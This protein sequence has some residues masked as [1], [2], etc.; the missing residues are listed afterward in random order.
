[1]TRVIYV[2]L[3]LCINLFINYFI[4]LSVV[5]ILNLTLKRFRLV[6][7][8]SL[9]A[10]Y[11]FAI[12]L[13]Q[14]NFFFSL[15]IK[16]IMSVSIVLL[17]FGHTKIRLF[18]KITAC[19]YTINFLFAGIIFFIWYFISANGIFMKNGMMYFDI[20]PLFLI[21]STLVTYLAMKI[22]HIFIGQRELPVGFCTV[23]FEYKGCS[24][25]L[26]AK[27]D[28][29]NTLREP[30]SNTPI[31]VTNYSEVKEM[32]KNT[33]LYKLVKNKNIA[34]SSDIFMTDNLKLRMVPY[35]TIMG[36]GLLPA[37]KVDK[38]II[39]Y[40]GQTFEKCA[41]VAIC[42]EN[43]IDTSFSALINPDLLNLY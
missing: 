2:D 10:L 7:A 37:F 41:F 6:L 21:G 25:N 11:S 14:M 42:K 13:P 24:V 8:S 35:K 26:K 16:L 27:I 33:E 40:R 23:Y 4:L 17:A 38:L 5:K 32:L 30:F 29:G 18:L 9:G 22:L 28:T 39:N 1:M 19:F 36:E 43:I 12:F 3:L 15:L 34:N 31:M 20:S